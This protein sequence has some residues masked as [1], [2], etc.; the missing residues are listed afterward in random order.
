M[1]KNAED[2]KDLLKEIENQKRIII[3]REQQMQAMEQELKFRP[4]LA[5]IKAT[6]YKMQS[7]EKEVCEL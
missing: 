6:E 7:L 4:N 1:K 2:Y 5:N 3:D